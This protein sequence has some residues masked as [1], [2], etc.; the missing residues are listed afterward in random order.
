MDILFTRLP[1]E[2]QWEILC[3]F[4]GTHVVRF[5]K[6]RRRLDGKIQKDI[7][8]NMMH[9]S[10]SRR[11]FLKPLPIYNP[12]KIPWLGKYRTVS[13]INFTEGGR[14]MLIENSLTGQLSSWYI[15]NKRWIVVILDD[16][17]VID[18]FVKRTYPSWES[19]DKKKGT[20]WQKVVLY[21]PSRT[22]AESYGNG[23]DWFCE[24]D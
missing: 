2:L 24:F 22:Y 12:D 10:D 14:R 19:T 6:L 3:V 17:L 13:I 4:V 7:L 18:P 20:E 23:S 1:T 11:L 15:S 21:D 9:Y 5:N 16:V 8:M